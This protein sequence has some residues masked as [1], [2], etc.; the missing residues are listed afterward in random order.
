MGFEQPREAGSDPILDGPSGE[1]LDYSETAVAVGAPP[2]VNRK[3]KDRSNHP[4]R[5]AQFANIIGKAQ[6]FQAAGQP[7]ISVDTKKK[8]WIG[9]FKS[10]GS[11]YGP[12]GQPVEVDAHDFENEDL[13]KVVPCGVYDGGA[14]FGYVG[15]GIDHDTARFA[16]NATRLWSDRMGRE[17]YPDAQSDARRRLRRCERTAFA[18]LENRAATADRRHRADLPGVQLR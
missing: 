7:V 9:E 10:P 13:G 14:D 15:L 8:E 17:R 1:R 16:V 3:T 6:E 12:K 4:D 11:D 2:H 18:A 5:D